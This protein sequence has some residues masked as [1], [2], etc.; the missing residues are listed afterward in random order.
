MKYI[1][2]PRPSYPLAEIRERTIQPHHKI[3]TNEENNNPT[4]FDRNM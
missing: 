1:G 3:S 4:Y 2:F